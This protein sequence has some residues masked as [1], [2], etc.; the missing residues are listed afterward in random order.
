[1]TACR[2]SMRR[3]NRLYRGGSY[4][5]SQSVPPPIRPNNSYF[6]DHLT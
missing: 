2:R 4:V 1:M 3:A 5:A 6:K